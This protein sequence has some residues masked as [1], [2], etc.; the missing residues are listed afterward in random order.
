MD[1]LRN[2][3]SQ[4]AAKC[5]CGAAVRVVR[6]ATA[7]PFVGCSAYPTCRKTYPW[8]DVRQRVR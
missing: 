2:A 3:L 7:D 8:P 4:L 1:T 5:D 6:V